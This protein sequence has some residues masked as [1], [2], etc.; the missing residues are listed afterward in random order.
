MIPLNQGCSPIGT[1]FAYVQ[2]SAMNSSGGFASVIFATSF[3]ARA[4]AYNCEPYEGQ[5]NRNLLLSHI[6][7]RPVAGLRG[8]DLTSRRRDDRGVSAM[9]LKE[10]LACPTKGSNVRLANS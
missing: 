8:L 3:L 10:S 5:G 9:H 2:S 4:Q 1:S 6:Q 7:P